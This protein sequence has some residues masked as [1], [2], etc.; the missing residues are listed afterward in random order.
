MFVVSK[1]LKR[2]NEQRRTAVGGLGGEAFPEVDT[3]VMFS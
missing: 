3:I 2:G 1:L